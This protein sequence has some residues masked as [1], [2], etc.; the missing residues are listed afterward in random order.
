MRSHPLQEAHRVAEAYVRFLDKGA[1]RT[2]KMDKRFNNAVQVIHDE[3]TVMFFHSAFALKWGIWHIVIAEH[4]DIHI[5]AQDEARVVMFKRI[6]EEVV[7]LDD[8][9]L[10]EAGI[11][12]AE[13]E[14]KF[15]P[16]PYGELKRKAEE[17]AK[18]DAEFEAESEADTDS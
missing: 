2:G 5:Y 4:H 1:R 17:E 15:G 9:T 6:D 3:G 7:T 18:L 12:I 16:D 11:I 14:L 13:L 8:E 10:A